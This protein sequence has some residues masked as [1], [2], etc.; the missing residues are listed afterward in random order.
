MNRTLKYTLTLGL[1]AAVAALAQTVVTQLSVDITDTQREALRWYARQVNK[2]AAA[3]YLAAGNTN[4]PPTIT[5]QQGAGQLFQARLEK[6]VR[7]HR[8]FVDAKVAAQYAAA[9][10]NT[11]AQIQA[12]LNVSDD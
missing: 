6:I 1:L 2:S 9:S 4:A 3:Q 5:W 10:T 12:L 8:A 11:Q 7:E